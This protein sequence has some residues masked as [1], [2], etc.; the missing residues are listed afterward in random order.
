[1]ALPIISELE[2][3]KR[4]LTNI[5]NNSPIGSYAKYNYDDRKLEYKNG[6]IVF[7]YNG[8][9]EIG[10]LEPRK[11][12]LI[13]W[14]EKII[15]TEK[16]SYSI[17][18]KENDGREGYG[19]DFYKYKGHAFPLDILKPLFAE[20]FRRC[21]K[22]SDEINDVINIDVSVSNFTTVITSGQ[23]IR[24]KESFYTSEEV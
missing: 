2:F 6:K 13:S 12:A 3:P 7:V 21:L 8:I 4:L 1:M 20:E 24:G 15:K 11:N 18:S 17:Y 9:S 22:T 19:S 16:D 5:K 23:V 10:N 14:I